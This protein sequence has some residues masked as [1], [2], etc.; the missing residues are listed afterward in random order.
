VAFCC[1]IT[2]QNW[3]LFWILTIVG[4]WKDVEMSQAVTSRLCAD[5]N[6]RKVL[7][8]ICN[9]LMY[10]VG[11]L[12]VCSQQ[13]ALKASKEKAPHNFTFAG[14]ELQGLAMLSRLWPK[15]LFWSSNALHIIATNHIMWRAA[16][17]QLNSLVRRQSNNY[18]IPGIFRESN[19]A[20]SLDRACL[21]V[22]YTQTGGTVWVLTAKK[23][24]RYW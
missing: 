3:L 2:C 14:A 12:F 21:I 24:A 15:L 19:D 11:R 7:L 6:W 10:N 1:D 13:A 16:M 8:C 23:K 17:A 9:K 22:D 18:K 20:Q 5:Q 4:L